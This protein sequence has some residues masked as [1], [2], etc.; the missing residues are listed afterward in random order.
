[1]RRICI[2]TL[3][4]HALPPEQAAV[5]RQEQRLLLDE[6]A[7]LRHAQ[8]CDLMLLPAISLTPTPCARRRSRPSAAA[9]AAAARRVFIAPGNH[10]YDAPGS[11]YRRSGWPDNVH[12]F[13]SAAP[14]AV[15]LE[16]LGA[17]VYGAAFTAAVSPSL[18]E[19][20]RVRDRR[21]QNLMVL[22]GIRQLALIPLIILSPAARLRAPGWTI[23]RWGSSMRPAGFAGPGGRPMPCRLRMGGGF[24]ELGEKGVF[25]GTL[26]AAAASWN[27]VRA[28]GKKI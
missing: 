5:R 21:L 25:L 12:I 3:P 7:E 1:M 9:S 22:H 23:W 24:D 18:L 16:D 11:P 10:D 26:D 2:W 28:A 4:F 19:G 13:H 6:L 20:F 15:V 14:E 17:A 27:S 8:R